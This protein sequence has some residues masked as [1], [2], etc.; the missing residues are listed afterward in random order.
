MTEYK[1]DKRTKEY[2]QWKK[3]HEAG[4]SG[5]GDVVE[6]ITTA[7]GIKKAVEFI[8]RDGR[9]CG[10]DRRKEKLNKLFPRKKPECFTEREYKLM[11]IAIETNKNK[12]TPDELKVYVDIYNRIFNT[13]VECVPCSFK[14]TVWDSLKKVYNQYN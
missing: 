2:K 7:T 13:K 5:L 11:K 4:V 9:D 6:K 10:C 1:G 8:F 14:S 12:F 3:N